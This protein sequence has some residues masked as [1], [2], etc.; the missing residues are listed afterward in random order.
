[1]DKKLEQQATELHQIV[2]ELVKKYQFRD[3]NEICCYGVSVSQCYALAAI[4]ERGQVT[5][6]ELAGQLHLTVSTMTRVVDQLVAKKL[7]NRWFDPKD[8]RV[9][10]V[11][12]TPAGRELLN[13]IQVELLATEKEILKKIKPQDRETLLFALRELSRAVDQ[14]RETRLVSIKPVKKKET[15]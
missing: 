14:W 11:E 2:T 10:C 8:R 3:R 1:M 9:C 5:M 15:L 7:V 4:G 12:L 6:G 13:K